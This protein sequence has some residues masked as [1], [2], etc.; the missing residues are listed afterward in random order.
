MHVNLVLLACSTAFDIA[1]DKG[2][3][4]GPPEFGSNELAG[5]EEARMTGSF[6]IVAMPKDGKAKGVIIGDINM[7]LVGQNAGFHLPVGKA[8]AEREWNVLMH[9]LK[10]L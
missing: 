7:A 6:M 3:K 8:G 2:G 10:R 5:F 1:A 9:G 4:T